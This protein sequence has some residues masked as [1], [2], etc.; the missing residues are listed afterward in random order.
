MRVEQD[1][2]EAWMRPLV[3]KQGEAWP[4]QRTMHAI[5]RG[6]ELHRWGP[7]ARVLVCR[8]GPDDDSAHLISTRRLLAGGL[9]AE[10]LAFVKATLAGWS[11]KHVWL[12]W[13]QRE[14]S[15]QQQHEGL[16]DSS[17]LRK[18]TRKRIRGWAISINVR[19]DQLEALI[20]GAA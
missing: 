20:G 6:G 12:A 9:S 19:I 18:V 7:G 4:S 10:E 1:E 14:V 8:A 17:G 3:G 13:L 5:L 2:V 15:M 16:L 11:P